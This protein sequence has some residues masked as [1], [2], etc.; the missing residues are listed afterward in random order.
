VVFLLVAFGSLAFVEG[1]IVG[2]LYGVAAAAI[3]IGARRSRMQ[4]VTA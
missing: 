1:Q 2:K 4:A 3:I